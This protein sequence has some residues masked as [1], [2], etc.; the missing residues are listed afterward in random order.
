MAEQLVH[1]EPQSQAA[2]T[3]AFRL[4]D[5]DGDGIITTDELGAV[6]KS[7]GLTPREAELRAMVRRLDADGSGTVELPEFLEVMARKLKADERVNEIRE[8][9]RVLD[10]D[11][12][13]FITPT[14]LRHVMANLG[15]RLSPREAADMIRQAD[16]DGDQQVNY[17]E[18]LLMMM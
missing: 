13:G 15:K 17:E 14:E 3:R 9:F 2:L 16:T 11:G 8:S 12:N 7:L 1:P 6:M 5:K 4:F 18:F 10:R